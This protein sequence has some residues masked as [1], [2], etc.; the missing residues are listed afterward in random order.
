MPVTA[1]CELIARH[2]GIP[3]AELTPHLYAH[4]KDRVV[5]HLLAVACGLDSMAVGEEQ[6]L[7]QVR[8][9]IRL[10][11]EHGAIGRVPHD[12]SGDGAGD[13]CFLGL[14]R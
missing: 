14:R 7:G 12:R 3:A 6:I 11:A 10:A 13:R 4:Y 8:S 2:S 9:A 5:T 1:I